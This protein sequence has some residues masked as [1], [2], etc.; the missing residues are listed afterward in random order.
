MQLKQTKHSLLRSCVC[1]I[2]RALAIFQ[3]EV[4]VHAFVGIAVN[5]PERHRGKR[6]EKRAERTQHAAEKARDDD[7]HAHE[8]QQDETDD[9]RADVE[10]LP[11]V[12]A[13]REKQIDQRQN[14]RA[15]GAM[16]QADGIEPADLQRAADGGGDHGDEDDVF[17]RIQFFVAVGLD[18]FALLRAAFAEQPA[19]EMMQNAVGTNPVA[20]NPAKQQRGQNQQQAPH[21]AHV[22]RVRGDG[23]GEGDQRVQF[24]EQRN[25]IALE[26]AQV[27]DE[28]EEQE[29]AEK[30]NLRHA[31]DVAEF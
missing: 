19:G 25:R 14:D 17:Q 30:E 7:V 10:V 3:A 9:P 22:N 31:A 2:G 29:Q 21:Q 27:G 4:A 24:Q 18:A 20:E 26:I 13:R 8:K 23:G 1:G 12:N 28:N 11:H 16:E 15:H 6:A 5:A